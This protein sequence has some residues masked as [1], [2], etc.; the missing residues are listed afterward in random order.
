VFCAFQS[1]SQI[2]LK[3]QLGIG[4]LE[5]L[6]TGITVGLK[7]NDSFSFLYGS[8]LFYKPRDFSTLFFNTTTRF[9]GGH[10]ANS[11]P[12]QASK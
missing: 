12:Q 8:N 5:H 9:S 4:Y 1:Q 6:S 3:G 7:K 11:S 2:S 10:L